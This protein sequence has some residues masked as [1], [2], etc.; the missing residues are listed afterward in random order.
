MDEE[1]EF[2]EEEEDFEED[3]L[4]VEGEPEKDEIEDD[5]YD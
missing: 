2:D 3:E 4:D 1:E 5:F